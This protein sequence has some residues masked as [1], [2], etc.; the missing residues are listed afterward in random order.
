[1]KKK[2]KKT[3]K[4]RPKVVR[5]H[6]KEITSSFANSAVQNCGTP[7]PNFAGWLLTALLLGISKHLGT[8]KDT[9][10]EITPPPLGEFALYMLLSKEDR[11]YLIGD[12]E[13]E[14]IEVQAKFGSKKASVWYYKQVMTSIWPL[15]RKGIRVGLLAWIGEWIR[16]RI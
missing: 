6:E 12:L 1:M 8:R 9:T 4:K 14:F 11:E 10:P 7:Q 15:M 3:S 16:R 5:P 13:E 2:R